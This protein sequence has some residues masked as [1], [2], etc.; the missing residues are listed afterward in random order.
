MAEPTSGGASKILAWICHQC[1]LCRY[2]R[3][4]PGSLIGRIL[5]HPLHAEYCPMWK[6]EQVIYG[7]GHDFDATRMR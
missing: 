1:P 7:S 5:H 2:G 4:Q 3:K 6:A